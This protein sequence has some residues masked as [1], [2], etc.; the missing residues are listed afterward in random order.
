MLKDI[1]DLMSAT[2]C[3]I[4]IFPEIITLYKISW[5]AMNN[6]RKASQYF[7]MKERERVLLVIFKI[8]CSYIDTNARGNMPL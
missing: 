1:V 8:I 6:N 7:T 5:K 4:V 3:N 2:R